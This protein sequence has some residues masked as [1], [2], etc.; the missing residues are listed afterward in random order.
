MEIIPNVGIDQ[1]VAN[2]FYCNICDYNTSKKFNYDK[3]LQTNK[4]KTATVSK[5]E[6]VAHS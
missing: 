2:W 6:I 5:M 4:H 1:K 3:H